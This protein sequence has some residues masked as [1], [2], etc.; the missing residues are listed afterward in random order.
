MDGGPRTDEYDPA[1]SRAA[2][3]R[4]NG[5]FQRSDE[6]VHVDLEVRPPCIQRRVGRSNLR[7]R[8]NGAGIQYQTIQV[9]MLG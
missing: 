6:R 8:L 1:P 9:T 7:Q 2:S 5:C 3:E 4:R